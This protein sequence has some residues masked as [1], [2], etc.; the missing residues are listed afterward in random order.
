MP[1]ASSAF[2]QNT[3]FTATVTAGGFTGMT[4]TVT[5]VTAT[6]PSARLRSIRAGHATLRLPCRSPASPT[7][8][9]NH[10]IAISTPATTTSP[11]YPGSFTET[12]VQAPDEH[13]ADLRLGQFDCRRHQPVVDGHGYGELQQH[14]GRLVTFVDGAT[15]LGTSTFSGTSS[16]TATADN[17][18]LEPAG[19][20]HAITAVY[21]NNDTTDFSSSTSTTLTQAVLQS[22]STTAVT[23]SAAS[24]TVFGTTVTFTATVSVTSNSNNGHCADRDRNLHG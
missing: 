15:T 2:G 18:S 11:A 6:V 4:G 20:T 16:S 10:A 24:S 8:L 1:I 14:A 19:A 13:G 3:T 23:T 17:H 7:A 21:N 9:G 12:I 22:T 5:F